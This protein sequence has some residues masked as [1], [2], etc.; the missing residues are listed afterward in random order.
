MIDELTGVI[1]TEN[2]RVHDLFSLPDEPEDALSCPF[3]GTPLPPN[4]QRCLKCG[5]VVS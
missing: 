4:G 5:K 2:L 3:C 1:N